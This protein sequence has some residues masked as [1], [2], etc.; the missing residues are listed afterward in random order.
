VNNIL[1][2]DKNKFEILDRR[3]ELNFKPL[4]VLFGAFAGLMF[5]IFFAF[6]LKVMKKYKE[7]KEN[8]KTLE[9]KELTNA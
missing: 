6:A 1:L 5:G 7:E 2:I 4:S 9:V 8:R 3:S